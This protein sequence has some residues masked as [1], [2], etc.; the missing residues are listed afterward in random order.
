[1]SFLHPKGVKGGRRFP[2]IGIEKIEKLEVYRGLIKVNKLVMRYIVAHLPLDSNP[3]YESFSSVCPWMKT[4][5]EYQYTAEQ[6]VHQTPKSARR[7]VSG[8]PTGYVLYV[9]EQ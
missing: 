5:T 4:A 3:C 8:G 9:T 7:L 1:M 2:F 6:K